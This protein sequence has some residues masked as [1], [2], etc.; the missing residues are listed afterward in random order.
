[1]F[2]SGQIVRIHLMSALQANPHE[3]ISKSVENSGRGVWTFVVSTYDVEILLIGKVWT[4]SAT[5]LPDDN[6]YPKSALS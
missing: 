6:T 1:M 3:T 2:A 4:L 5:I